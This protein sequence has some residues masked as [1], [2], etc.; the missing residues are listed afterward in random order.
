[1]KK[2]LPLLLLSLLLAGTLA[3]T[4]FAETPAEGD[5]CPKCGEGV[6]QQLE[7]FYT[8]WLVTGTLRCTEDPH[9][10][11]DQLERSVLSTWRC[12]SCRW[13][14]C[15]T[16]TETRTAHLHNEYFLQKFKN[17]TL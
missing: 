6:L 2:L 16:E 3:L 13:G 5:P 17:G 8:P 15:R 7:T 4:A 1:M 9:C 11:D 14:V 10:L 12:D